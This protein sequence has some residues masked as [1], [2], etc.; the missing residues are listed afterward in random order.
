[1]KKALLPVKKIS[2]ASA[3]LCGKLPPVQRL[4]TQ[5]ILKGWSFRIA[6]DSWRG[7]AAGKAREGF[8]AAAKSLQNASDKIAALP[9]TNLASGFDLRKKRA[10]QV[11]GKQRLHTVL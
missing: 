10:S 8:R 2:P 5:V 6:Y 4:L 9:R 7:P 3:M 1:M 11:S